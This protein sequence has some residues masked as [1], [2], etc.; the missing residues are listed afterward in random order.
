MILVLQDVRPINGWHVNLKIDHFLDEAKMD[1]MVCLA[2]F[3]SSFLNLY[4]K[5]TSNTGC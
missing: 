3:R 4:L 1:Q 5:S 2:G